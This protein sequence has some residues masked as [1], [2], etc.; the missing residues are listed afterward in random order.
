MRRFL[1]PV[2]CAVLFS[3]CGILY[4]NIRVPYQYRTATPSEVKASPDDPTVEGKSCDYS[5][6]FLV[7]WGNTGYLAST[8]A[9]LK[10]HPDG[11]LYDV[12]NDVQV[13][14]LPLGIFTRT[15][16]I[17]RGKVGHV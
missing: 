17:V 12:K 2:L 6:L 10:G 8:E 15:C 7:A 3:G 16:T 1:L 5:V 14:V 9:A 4:T 13:T 11:I